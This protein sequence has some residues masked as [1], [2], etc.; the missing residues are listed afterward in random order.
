M[1]NVGVSMLANIL[2][3]FLVQF[4][5]WSWLRILFGESVCPECNIG[6]WLFV[7]IQK[8]MGAKLGI[9]GEKNKRKR[10]GVYWF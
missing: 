6:F 5:S 3:L 2:Y 9:A 4:F 7:D 10:N 8:I 1:P